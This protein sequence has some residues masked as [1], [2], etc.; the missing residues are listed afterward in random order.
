MKQKHLTTLFFVFFVPFFVHAQMMGFTEIDPKTVKEWR[1]DYI[2]DYQ[3]IYHFGDS[4][5]ESELIIVCQLHTVVAQLRYGQWDYSPEAA[6][7]WIAH[8]VNFTNVRIEGDHFYSDQ[9]NGEF[10]TYEYLDSTIYGIKVMD[11]YM[12]YLDSGVYELSFKLDIEIEKYIGGDYPFTFTTFL[13][14]SSIEEFSKDELAIMRNEI[15]A[16][17]GY[18]FRK[19]GKMESYFKD[20][21]WYSPQ[22]TNVDAF[23]T[24]IEKYN[25]ELILETEK[26]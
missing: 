17:Y 16:R 23:I 22:Y 3:G 20:K 11:Q 4:E 25:I 7:P 2:S 9:M 14:P 5:M 21:Q 26:K 8:Y 12:N 18:I 15:S 10:V 1:S 24:E 6:T 13:R 19:G